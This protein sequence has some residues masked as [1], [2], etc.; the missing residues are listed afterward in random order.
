MASYISEWPA[1][2]I[3]PSSMRFAWASE[4]ERW[5]PE[6]L[7]AQEI[8]VLGGRSDV[9]RLSSARVSIASYSLFTKDSAVSEAARMQLFREAFSS[10]AKAQM[11][12]RG[13]NRL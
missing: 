7:P 5:L 2:V 6:V 3:C 8:N 10:P 13:G 12:S 1:L 11:C 9:T 4:L